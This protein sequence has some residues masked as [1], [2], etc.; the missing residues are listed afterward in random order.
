MLADLDMFHY[1]RA[2]I[3]QSVGCSQRV[4]RWVCKEVR[5]QAL[6]PRLPALKLRSRITMAPSFSTSVSRAGHVYLSTMSKQYQQP[7]DIVGVGGV[8]E[9]TAISIAAVVIRFKHVRFS[10]QL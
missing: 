5:T 10:A 7:V 6:L 8:L 3:D 4:T 2:P 1:P 9:L